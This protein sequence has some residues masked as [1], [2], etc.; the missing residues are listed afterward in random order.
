ML[1]VGK[2]VHTGPPGTTNPV[3]P[4]TRMVVL[5]QMA[6]EGTYTT[7]SFVDLS[8]AAAEVG[9]PQ[10]RLEGLRK[11][12]VS[13][14]QERCELLL[15]ISE[16]RKAATTTL[17]TCEEKSRLSSL[18]RRLAWLDTDIEG[19]RQEELVLTSRLENIKKP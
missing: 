16:A 2:L 5:E 11:E 17:S 15:S 4:Q 14:V 19:L 7:R 18:E 3:P 6:T 13:V 1:R 10:R 9:D 8:I 12:V